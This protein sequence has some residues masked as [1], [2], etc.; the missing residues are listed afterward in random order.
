[1]VLAVVHVIAMLVLWWFGMIF[2]VIYA[3]LGI[4]SLALWVVLMIKEYNLVHFR[5][6][7]IGKL[8]EQWSA[9]R[10]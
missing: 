7:I 3:I 1:M 6:P 10:Q 4:A 2:T 8:A 5:L 9:K